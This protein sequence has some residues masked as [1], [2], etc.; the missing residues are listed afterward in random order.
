MIKWLK[1][2][3][4]PHE[5]NDHRPYIL[6]TRATIAILAIVLL[7]EACFL[8]QIVFFSKTNLFA[9]IL[10]SVLVDE[11]NS[12][13]QL[14]SLPILKENQL[15]NA[16]AK[17]K[18]GDMAAKDYFA[19]TSPEGITPWYWLEKVG[20]VYAYAG[21][22]LAINFSDS[23][24]VIKAWLNSPAHRQNILNQ[25]F[26]EIGIGTA[27]GTYEGRDTVFIVQMFGNPIQPQA[28]ALSQPTAGRLLVATT[29]S[30][31]TTAGPLSFTTTSTEMFVAVKGEAESAVLSV[32]AQAGAT[33][34]NY[35]A[36]NLIQKIIA[37]PKTTSGY[38]YAILIAVIALAF[39]LNILIR[40][41]IQ[42]PQLILNGVIMLL[43]INTVLLLNHYLALAGT[44][45]L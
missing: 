14:E 24:D 20:Y 19:H 18:A 42:H 16:A 13:R 23:D 4:I 28:L 17:M 15:L 34:A 36:S 12:N 41:R 3:F 7:I 32:N 37:S 27:M 39:L 25:H 11:T 9:I 5:H 44:A 1:K 31:V 29:S 45:I 21:E 10:Q 35:P 40:V 30:K 43:I 38:L 22:N 26:T 8:T 2:H 33:K 6:R